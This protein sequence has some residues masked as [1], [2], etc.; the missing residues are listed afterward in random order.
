MLAS[1]PRSAWWLLALITTLAWFATLDARRLQHPDEG[2]YAEIAREMAASGDWVTPRLNDL[3]YFEKPPLQY[4]V[5][6]A[7][8]ETLGVAEW[9][10][11]LPS[12]V[13]GFLA[14]IAVGFTGARLAGPDAGVF[15]ALAL[16][17][18]VWH[19]GLSQILT[20][21]AMLSFWLTTALC[22]FLLAQRAALAP[23]TR[24]NWML[25]AYAAAAGATL[26]KGLV[27]LVIP[28][29][30]LVVYSLA[31]R[32]TGPWRRL[33]AVPGLLLYLA[34]TAPWFLLVSYANP[35]FARFFFIHEHFER[36]LTESHNRTGGWY[37]FIPWLALGLLPWL[38]VWAWTLPRS[39]R[40]ATVDDNGFA[41][42]RFCVCWAAFVFVFFSVSG[43][44]LP[45]YILPMFPALALIVGYELTRLSPR[46]LAWIALPLA[47]GAPLLLAGYALGYGYLVERL[48]SD[49]TPASIYTAFG[50]WLGGAL[51]VFGTGGIAA[52]LLFRNESAAAR[53]WGIAALALS[54]LIGLQLALVGHDA[55]AR[56]RSAWFILQDAQ[57]ANGQAFDPAFP[58]YQVGSYDQTLPFYLRR[59]TP[60]VEY[61]DEMGPGLDAEPHKGYH[62]AAWIEAW[63]AAPQAYALMSPAL[64]SELARRNVPLRVLARDPRRVFVARR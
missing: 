24:R 52:F 62:E 5:G 22:A 10:A 35:E 47:V 55:F 64:A 63:N 49:V 42:E 50:R 20:L 32:D 2:R 21:D 40:A 28:G 33:H 8:F 26:T 6:A 16:A 30:A 36:F 58:V 53:S 19:V 3:K 13:A 39:W 17:G 31:T 41:W 14:V 7:T 11:R 27:A 46:T 34:L 57:R 48:A 9:T 59:P 18:T 56:V 45:S 25:V 61:R 12:A 43:S 60:L 4:W 44:K 54:T 29:G 38:L 15:T 23:A 51:A 37:Y 1:L